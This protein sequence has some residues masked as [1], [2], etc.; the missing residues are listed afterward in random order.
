MTNF[1]F[2]D[3]VVLITGA[4]SGIGRAAAIAFARAGAKVMATDIN[5][6]SAAKTVADIVA[7]GSQAFSATLDVANHADVKKTVEA[8]V[9]QLGRLDIALNNA[10]IG[11]EVRRTSDVTLEDWDRVIAVNQTGVFYCMRE[12]LKQMQQ[13]ESGVIVNVAS[14]A[15]MKALPK[16]M[17]YTASKHA[18][19]GMTKAAALEYAQRN[20]RINAVCPVFTR[21][22]L[23]EELFSH[24]EGIEQ[25][26]LR[27]I[28]VGRFGE[29]ADIVNAILWLSAEQSSF[30]T[31]LSL[32]VDGGQTA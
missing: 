7:D 13:Q 22:A 27:G 8:T 24:R 11:G 32:P 6:D 16:Q 31:G 20:I 15:G 12:E 28:P 10:G 14:I 2:S 30:I 26:L 29:P 9:A 18:V 4:G 3:K 19:I 25:Q 1:D 23:L 5:G 17:A 21:S